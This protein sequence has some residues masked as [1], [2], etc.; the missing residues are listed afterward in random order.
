MTSLG[1]PLREEINKTYSSY[2]LLVHSLRSDVRICVLGLFSVGFCEACVI[3]WLLKGNWDPEW[4]TG[5][6]RRGRFH[7]VYTD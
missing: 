3:P 4:M 7:L 1:N 5:W 2:I 6:S